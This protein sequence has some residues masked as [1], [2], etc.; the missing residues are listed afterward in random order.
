MHYNK[1]VFWLSRQGE[2]EHRFSCGGTLTALNS[3]RKIVDGSQ[4]LLCYPLLTK[5][6]FIRRLR[7]HLQSPTR[8]GMP[9]SLTNLIVTIRTYG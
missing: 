2:S 3:E 8:F 9:G 4:A 5:T 7:P 1:Q 6:N